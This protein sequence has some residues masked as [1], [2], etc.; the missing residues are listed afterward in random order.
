M[1]DFGWTFFECMHIANN[2]NYTL[3]K[4]PFPNKCASSIVNFSFK[5]LDGISLCS[6]AVIISEVFA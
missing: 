3:I 5:V 6:C 1:A 2:Y 4:L